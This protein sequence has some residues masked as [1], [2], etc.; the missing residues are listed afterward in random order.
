MLD[1][2]ISTADAIRHLQVAET[3]V[4]ALDRRRFLQLVGLG[5][6]AG[7]LVGPASSML[8]LS[9]PGLDP[10]AWAAG[11]A[12]PND[13][14]LIVIG[15]FG[16]ND[17]LN[18]VV[19]V[20]D[21]LYYGQ[22]RNLAIAPQQTLPIDA[23]TG[24]HP[25]L[26]V[27]KQFWDAGQLAIVEGVGYPDPDLSHFNSMAKWMAGSPT[28]IPTSGWLGRWL[29]G[30]IGGGKDLYAAAQ[31]GQSV[32]LHLVGRA[33]RG[34]AVPAGRP[35]FGASTSAGDR[36]VYDGVRR[37]A[38]GDPAT[39]Q[40]RVGQAMIDQLDLAGT[41]A[42]LIPD[43]SAMSDMPLVA[44][45]EVMA[46]LVNA[47]LGLRVLSAGWGDF[48]SHAGQPN[49]HSTRMRELNTAVARF[50]QVLA[51]AWA[52]RVTIMTFSEFG[53]TSWSNDGAGTDHGTSAPHFVLGANVRGGRYGERPSLAGLRR[54]DRMPFH[55]DFRDY[56]GSVID[57]WL[58]GGASDVLGG[59]A[60]QNL[61][62]F[63]RA[64]GVAGPPP[65]STTPTPT[66]TATPSAG[67]SGALASA[68]RFV[69]LAPQRVCD[70]RGGLGGR[71]GQVGPGETLAVQIAGVGGV[72]STG[73]TAV[74]VNVTSVNATEPGFFSVFP[75]NVAATDTSSLNL[76]PGRAVPNMAI[77]GV[78]PDGR[79]GVFN[80]VGRADCIVDVMGYVR[81]EPAAGLLPL[82]PSRVLDS[83]TGVGAPLARLRGGQRLDLPVAGRGG[84]PSNGVDAVVLNVAA[85]RPTE[86]GFLTVWPSGLGLPDVSNLNYEPG[87]N[88]PNLV[89]CKL[90]TDGAVSLLAN[91]GELDLIADVVG[92]FTADGASVMPVTPARL[93]DTRHGIGARQ[94][95]VGATGDIDLAVAGVGGVDPAASAVIL[96]IT[97]TGASEETFVT[98]YPDGVG[99]PDA[100]SLNVDRGG[101]IANLVIAKVGANG[102]VRLYNDAGG[103]HLL[104]D[105]TGYFI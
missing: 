82:V 98:V 96:N 95:V 20:N 38:V 67:T 69:A 46:R 13:G 17:G 23:A 37:L 28:G 48:D 56:Y 4:N 40:G 72:P 59:R 16:G 65:P 41:L 105:V 66:T 51:P 1:S 93:L 86:P 32:P 26:T 91:T 29:D 78:G 80:A 55:V 22:H 21:Q 36:K 83:R 75:S 33:Q 19:P 9:L 5:V 84:V 103:V 62:L 10:S 25:E 30:Y 2:D 61:A 64:P 68:G 11:P 14:V 49:Q 6:G 7:A 76:V 79:I 85:L 43:R 42:P 34:T 18:T 12:G 52:S 50:F 92:C 24:L 15:M 100:S 87:R 44:E 8:D 70:T 77:V 54:W 90:G 97:A 58:G 57:G 101:T 104:A 74:A 71:L 102:R 35:S 31:I 81:S 45:M 39:W 73:V 53:R 3:D 99:R 63:A 47:N 88:V 60:V 94:G 27:F 89:I